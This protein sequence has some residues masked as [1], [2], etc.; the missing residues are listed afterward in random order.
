MRKKSTKIFSIL[1]GISLSAVIVSCAT[2]RESG[3]S[4]RYPDGSDTSYMSRDGSVKEFTVDE[5]KTVDEFS[6]PLD[7]GVQ[8][9]SDSLLG[10]VTVINFW[11]AGCPPCRVE[12]KDLE[13]VHQEFLDEHVEFI[14]VNVRDTE[15]TSLA[16]AE[17]FGVT[18]NSLLD[19]QKAEA[20]LAFAGVVPPNV[21]PTTLV[22]DRNNNVA[23]RILGIVDQS[24]LRTLVSDVLA[25]SH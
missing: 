22:L 18:Y 3:L 1:L 19:V 9:S 15:S 2:T 8:F 17:N 13:A 7:S 20:Q 10:N 21:V 24:I 5:R 14:G 23:A 6:G 11:Y 12:A 4:D 25:E 16:F